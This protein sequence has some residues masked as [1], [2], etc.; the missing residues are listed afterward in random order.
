MVPASPL[1]TR[2][3]L[4][5]DNSQRQA[6]LRLARQRTAPERVRARVREEIPEPEPQTEPTAPGWRHLDWTKVATIAGVVAGIG[7]LL[8][9]GVATYFGAEVSQDQLAQSREDAE[10]A[11][12]AQAQRVSWWEDRNLDGSLRAL[13]VMNRSPDPVTNLSIQFIVARHAE[14]RWYPASLRQASLA[15]CTVVTIKPEDVTWR[16]ASKSKMHSTARESLDGVYELQFWDS[17]GQLWSREP[18]GNLDHTRDSMKVSSYAQVDGL[19]P[20]ERAEPCEDSS[21]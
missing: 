19:L 17:D 18:E 15:P 3:G 16:S 4:V 8:F 21:R 5:V 14:Q 9:T 1:M 7:S 12:R 20:T 11:D 10:R 2:E 6:R 13:Y